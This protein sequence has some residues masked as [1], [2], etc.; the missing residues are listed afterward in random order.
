MNGF[1]FKTEDGVIPFGTIDQFLYLSQ[2][3]PATVLQPGSDRTS[4]ITSLVNFVLEPKKSF[5]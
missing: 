5:F 2:L 4:N 1:S 3:K